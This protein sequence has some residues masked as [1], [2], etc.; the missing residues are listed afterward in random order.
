MDVSSLARNVLWNGMLALI[1]VVIARVFT[2]AF[3]SNR[4]SLK[5]LAAPLLFIIWLAFLPNTCYLITEWRHF[6][7]YLDTNDLFIRSKT[8]NVLFAE[9]CALWFFYFLYSGFGMLTFALSIRPIEHIASK[10]HLATWP[11]AFLFFTLLSL[12][13]YLGLILRFNSWDIVANPQT[14]WY[15]LLE[16][17]RRPRL[18]LFIIAFGIFLWLSYKA[19]DI[20]VDGIKQKLNWK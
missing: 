5:Y 9:L 11:I 2:G 15:S 4:K 10:R 17:G 1:P 14:L 6:L 12:G 18:I 3:L 20:W 8:D 16:L 13:V 7:I 19:L